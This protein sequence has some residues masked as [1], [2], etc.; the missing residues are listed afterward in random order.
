MSELEIRNPELSNDVDNFEKN[1]IPIEI[2]ES[3]DDISHFEFVDEDNTLWDV[4][5][6][7]ED[8][9]STDFISG[10]N[11]GLNIDTIVPDKE[12]WDTQSSEAKKAA[13]YVRSFDGFEKA[14]DYVERHFT[15][16]KF[17]P[18]DIIPVKTRNQDMADNETDIG[19]QFSRREIVLTDG[20]TIEGV[21]PE[22]NSIHHVDLGDSVKDMSL[23]Q[24]FSAC[25]IDFQDHLYDNPQ[26][27]ERITFGDME[28]LD[29]P[30]GYAPDGYT[31]NHNPET[32]SYDL[33]LTDDH[34]IGHTGGNAFW[35]KPYP[36][37]GQ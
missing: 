17:T 28:R 32:G 9:V 26:K 16:E 8:N 24:Q 21:F 33:V 6:S 13:D 10:I 15:S 2:T 22:F 19:V 12:L 11:E 34:I 31:W 1:D 25:K 36:T 3:I 29:K 27:L 35:G 7:S 23:H 20:L 4:K 37:N 5:K 18:G 30:Q 14:A